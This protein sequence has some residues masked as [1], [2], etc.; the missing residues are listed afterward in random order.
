MSK[1]LTSTLMHKVEPLPPTDI[2]WSVNEG[3]DSIIGVSASISL[4]MICV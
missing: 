1:H 4:N 2:S 3:G